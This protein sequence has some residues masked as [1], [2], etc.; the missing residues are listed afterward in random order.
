MPSAVPYA[1][2]QPRRVAKGKASIDAGIGGIDGNLAVGDGGNDEVGW[3]VMG[4]RMLDMVSLFPATLSQ[5]FL[6]E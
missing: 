4:R 5:D 6:L 2:H 3:S 1:N